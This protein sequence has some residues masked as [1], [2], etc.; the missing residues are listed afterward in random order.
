MKTLS[1]LV[2]GAVLLAPVSALAG[3]P[4]APVP[5]ETVIAP[6]IVTPTPDWTGWYGGVSLGYADVSSGGVANGSG[7]IGGVLGGYRYDF[8]QWV[9]GAEVDYDWA[10]FDLN[11]AGTSSLDAI[12]RFKIQA[13]ADIGQTFLYGTAGIARAD[14]TID[15]VSINSNGWVAGVGADY[16]VTDQWLVGGEILYNE[17]DDFGNSGIDGDGTTFKLRAAFRF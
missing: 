4:V 13:G 5:E 3:G 7:V 15:N 11:D 10:G 6:V 1:A 8:G 12:Y 9:L 16:A 14:T 2:F 17:F